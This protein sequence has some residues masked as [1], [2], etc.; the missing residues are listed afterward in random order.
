MKVMSQATTYLK[1]MYDVHGKIY[2]KDIFDD[3]FCKLSVNNST[4]WQTI[5]IFALFAGKEAV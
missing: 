2:A 5:N 1:L 3:F 4:L